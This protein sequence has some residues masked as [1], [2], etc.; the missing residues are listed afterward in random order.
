[1]SISQKFKPH[2][3][4]YT[5]FSIR[6]HSEVDVFNKIVLIDKLISINARYLK[7]DEKISDSKLPNRGN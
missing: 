3:S 6:D 1:M 5:F 4:F 2:D 7:W